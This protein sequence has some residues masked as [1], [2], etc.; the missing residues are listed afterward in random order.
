M[1]IPPHHNG[2]V[3]LVSVLVISVI[4]AATAASMML[5]GWAAEQNGYLLVQSAQAY[6]YAQAC[7]ERAL[8]SLSA[9]MGYT[10]NEVVTFP[11]G[12]CTIGPPGGNGST[13]R[14]LCVT[15]HSGKVTR[16]MEVTIASLYPTMKIRW[17]KEV[18]VFTQCI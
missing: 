17:W 9:D 3:F 10:G 5:L 2:Y 15:G 8:L 11:K 7:T 13:N 1:R 12:S 16:R 14:V 18:A 4:A 6:E